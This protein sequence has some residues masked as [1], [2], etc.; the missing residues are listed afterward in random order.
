M[1]KSINSEFYNLLYK[2]D[3]AG[4]DQAVLDSSF[5]KFMAIQKQCEQIQGNLSL[6]CVDTLTSLT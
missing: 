4:A 1:K 5:G 6:T 3:W 2:D